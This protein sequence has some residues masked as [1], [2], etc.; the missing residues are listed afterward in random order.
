MASNSAAVPMAACANQG[1]D[2]Y[3]FSIFKSAIE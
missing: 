2:D 1:A 3:K